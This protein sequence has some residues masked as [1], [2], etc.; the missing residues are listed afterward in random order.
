VGPGPRIR[1]WVAAFGGD[2]ESH[3]HRRWRVLG[4]IF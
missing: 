1:G 3:Y 4:E 2:E